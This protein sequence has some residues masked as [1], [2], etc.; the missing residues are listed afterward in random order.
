MEITP[1]TGSSR[2]GTLMLHLLGQCN[3]TCRH[4]YMQGSPLRREQLQL[5]RVMEAVESSPAMDIGTLYLT[6]GE[7]LLYQ[8]L[9]QVLET[10]ARVPGLEVTVCTNATLMTPRHV[11]AFRAAKVKTSIS[12][13]GEAGFHDWFRNSEGAFQATEKGI[14]LLAEAGVP[15]TVI[16]TISRANVES[17]PAL[18]DW[19]HRAGATQFRAQP[20]LRL[21]RALDIMDQRLSPIQL[22]RMVMRL[23]DL[24]NLYRGKGMRISIIGQNRAFLMQHPCGAYVCNG[25]GCHRKVAQEIKKVVVREDGTVLPEATNLDSSYAIGHF[26]DD[27]LLNMV[28]RY[29]EN[30]GYAAFDRLCRAAYHEVLPAWK[31]IVVP[32]DQIIAERSRAHPA[33]TERE[34]A[35]TAVCSA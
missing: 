18:V 31:C 14:H 11:E 16:S 6:G 34:Y 17:L 3:L 20:L 21:G 27:V 9:H 24:A 19:A 32:W 28:Q 2:S 29:F 12:V 8:G 7:P 26:D 15:I 33:G 22:E 5:E 35:D 13:D 25:G 23:S 30:G 10:A 4:C 1:E